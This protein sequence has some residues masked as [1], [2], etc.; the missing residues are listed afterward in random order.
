MKTIVPAL[1]IIVFGADAC[2]ADELK[3]GSN[4]LTESYILAEI[5]AQTARGAGEAAVTHRPGLGNTAIL[6][7]ALK[8]GAIDLY[9]EY[10]GTIVQELLGGKVADSVESINAALKPIGLAAGI[11]LGFSNSYALAVSANSPETGALRTISDL[12]KVRSL[13]LGLSQEFLN[14]KDG[15]P[16][17]QKHYGLPQLPRGL[18]HGLA[19]DVIAAAQIDVMDVYTTDAKISR[20]ALRALVDDRQFFPH[21]D[22]L[23]LYRA[24][25]PQ[26]LPKSWGAIRMLEQKIRAERM[27]EL[28]AAVEL[29]G[30]TFDAAPAAF[31]T[32]NAPPVTNRPTPLLE[33]LIGEDF[34]RLAV[35]HC[36][37]VF[38]SL[39]LSALAGIPLGI[40]AARST[41]AHAFIMPSV[42]VLQTIPSLA[43]L[44]ILIAVLGR[45]GTLPA[46]VALF[47]Y[48]LLPVV[49]NTATGLSGIPPGLQQ[50]AAAVGLRAGAILTNIE[51]PLAAP[52]I[53]AGIR[54]SAVINVGTATIAAFIGAGGFGERIVAGLAVNDR[55]MLLAGALP[56]ALMAIA[57]EA[58]F[59]A[60]E[61]KLAFPRAGGHRC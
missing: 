9:P 25:L 51:L 33:R 19:F 1:L 26:R 5:V 11:P 44:A 34:G 40:W 15:W 35:Q 7:A 6:F 48:G 23:L 17:L 50:A 41:T 57:I 49:R 13:R 27:I 55:A 2:L 10:S 4:R 36:V 12:A 54:I 3:V 30:Q 46:V 14:R 47:L 18:D 53:L 43:L 29:K 61:R 45:I 39:S 32:T 31:V 56:A 42:G 59:G 28:N 16:A 60:W 58:G 8:S 22:A 24:D 52:T 21:Y 37:L 38:L 20:F